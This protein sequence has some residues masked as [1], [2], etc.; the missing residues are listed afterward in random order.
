MIRRT[1][2]LAL[3]TTAWLG[4]GH[5]AHASVTGVCSNCHT[6]HN[7]QGGNGVVVGGGGPQSALLVTT[8]VGCHQGR[9][10]SN[11]E[12]PYVF[13]PNGPTY[14]TTGTETNTNTLAGGNFYWVSMGNDASGHNVQGI[15]GQDSRHGNTPPGGSALPAQLTCAGAYGC[16]GDRTILDQ[17]KSIA[18]GHHNHQVSGW[19]SGASIEESYRFL[20][21]IKGLESAS[22][23]YHP[24]TT[25][26]NKYYGIDRSVETDT[27]TGSI[28]SLCA[29][30]HGQFHDGSGEMIPTGSSFGSGIWLRHPT[31]FD[32]SRAV[33]RRQEYEAYNGGT[34]TDNPYS[35]VSPVATADTTTNLNTTVFSQSDDAIV[36][37][38]SC[39]RA[40]G[41]PYDAILRW[42]YKSWPGGGYNGC[43]VC[44]TSKD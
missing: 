9:N 34:G 18:G 17:A 12:T 32:M 38:L 10:T 3:V 44:H 20:L 7:S 42:D 35:V 31:D 2:L 5:L 11:S 40:H 21:G 13:D 6:M 29:Q 24:T 8:C 41:T 28:S 36:M 27:A 22:Y 39:H 33:A 43:A 14:G 25:D 15:A 23:E 37:C 19:K 1:I 26:H 30:C 4:L 16:H